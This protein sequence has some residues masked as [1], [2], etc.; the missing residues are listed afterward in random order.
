MIYEHRSHPLLPRAA[1]LARVARHS[2][3]A[4]V[5]TLV[6]LGIGMWGYHAFEGLSW[7]DAYLNASMLMG[8]MGPVDPPKTVGGKIF[9]GTYALYCGLVLLIVAGVV[10]A[11]LFHRL[12]HRFHLQQED[13]EEKATLPRK[14][15]SKAK[16]KSKS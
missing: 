7:V 14:P 9:A 2:G 11:P 3:I 15:T 8:G 5:A 4:L 6:S 10:I 16:G 12:L 1:F 13:E